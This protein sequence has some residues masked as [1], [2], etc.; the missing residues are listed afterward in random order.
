MTIEEKKYKNQVNKFFSLSLDLMAIAGTDGYFKQVN[1]AFERILGYTPKEMT[2]QPAI[3]FV[4]PDDAEESKE[5]LGRL[6]QGEQT[7]NFTN[8]C[9]CKDGS[10]RWISWKAEADVPNGLIYA[11]GWDVTE[12]KELKEQ[13]KLRNERY[14]LAIEGASAGIWDWMDTNKD[15]QW[16]SPVF[17]E[18]L[19][20]ED[21]EITASLNGFK[22]IIHPDDHERTFALVKDHFRNHQPF[23]IEYR[24]RTKSGIYQWFSGSAQADFDDERKPTRMVGTITNIEKRKNLEE[25]LREQNEDLKKLNNTAS[26]IYSVIGHDLR[27]PINAITG[28]SEILLMDIENYEDGNDLK[29]K[30][31]MINHSAHNVFRLLNDLLSWARIQT[32]DLNLQIEHFSAVDNI[33]KTIDLLS[34]SA[35]K[36]GIQLL[37]TPTSDIEVEGD[38]R[39]ITTIS[40]NLISNAIKYSEQGD[41]INVEL[42]RDADSWFLSIEDEGTGM[43]EEIKKGLFAQKLNQSKRGTDNEKGTGLG[44]VLCKE[45]AEMHG[46][47]IEVESEP[48]K[49]STFILRIPLK[50][51]DAVEI[52][53]NGQPAG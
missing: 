39:M 45:L 33:K 48:D 50:I 24:L 12:E 37:F 29:D 4:H 23:D 8:R 21:Q 30:L 17:Y 52:M 26:K 35:Q 51:E 34:A 9:L 27:S 22:K 49:G 15:E 46:G 40:R 38:K 31:E 13:L 1:P 10:Y 43:P 47:I 42:G 16:W 7:I 36:K 3:R 32:D 41:T 18:L 2:G 11:T 5:V 28:F 53:Q 19:G 44:L 20:Y 14:G 25:Q 6:A